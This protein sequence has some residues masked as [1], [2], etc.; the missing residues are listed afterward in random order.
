MIMNLIFT[1]RDVDAGH[2][3]MNVVDV[4][5]VRHQRKIMGLTQGD[6][7]ARLGRTTAAI[8]VQLHDIDTAFRDQLLESGR[9]AVLLFLV[10][11]IVAGIALVGGV[12]GHRYVDTS[13]WGG[14]MPDIVITFVNTSVALP[15]GVL[16]ALGRQSKCVVVRLLPTAY[17]EFWRGVPL[18]SVLFTA[19]LM[20]P[21]AALCSRIAQ[22]RPRSR[23]N[24]A[25][26][27]VNRWSLSP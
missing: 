2:D 4:R 16:L 27:G 12:C 26:N 19:T 5:R 10:F 3:Q 7:F 8:H 23:V 13:Q 1:K 14:L 24:T 17:I 18:L 6:D 11:P 20:L 21:S 15:T 9:W 25:L 22:P